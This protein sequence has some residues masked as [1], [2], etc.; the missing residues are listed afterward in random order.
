MHPKPDITIKPFDRLS[1]LELHDCLRLRSE[2]FV[3]G[4]RVCEVP[5]VDEYD[6]ACHHVLLRVGGEVV[7][8]ARLLPIDGGAVVKVGRVAVDQAHRGRG[9][10]TA[11]MQAVN[12]WIDEA[13]VG[14]GVMSAQA[15]LA[16]WYTR[17]GWRVVGGVYAEAG[18]DHVKMVCGPV[19]GAEG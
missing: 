10:G 4:Q 18:I 17:L 8:T 11:L 6:L 12:E 14:S 7:G 3:V 19:A 15:H 13:A 9:L 16:D 2:V 1:L 5:D